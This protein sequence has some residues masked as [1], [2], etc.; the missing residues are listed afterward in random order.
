MK[1]ELT[2]EERISSLLFERLQLRGL[3]AMLRGNVKM[4]AGDTV[5]RLGE[6]SGLEM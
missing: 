4:R 6:R 5:W 2:C 1:A 3:F